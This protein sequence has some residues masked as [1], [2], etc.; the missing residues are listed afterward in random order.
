[1]RMTTRPN[2]PP[3]PCAHQ[4]ASSGRQWRSARI[5]ASSPSACWTHPSRGPS[6]AR[7]NGCCAWP[8]AIRP[9]GWM[10]RVPERLASTWSTCV[11]SSA[12]WCW[13][14]NTKANLRHLPTSAC[15]RCPVPVSPD[16]AVPSII[17][18][19]NRLNVDPDLVRL[20]KRLKLGPLLPTLPERLTL[21]RAQQ[22]DYVA[23]LTLLLADE[24]QRRD[25]QALERHLVQAGFEDRVTLD[26]FDWTSP[27]Q[28][29]RR[30][31]QQVFSLEFLARKE[32]VVFV[33]PV[34]V[35]KTML[36][37]SL[38][39]TS[40]RAGHSVL[41]IRA[42]A[43]LAELGQARADRSYDKVFRRYLAPDLVIL[44]DFG[45][46][47]LTAQQSN[48][49][50]ELIVERHRRASFAIT[51]NRSVDEWLGL[52]DD[53]ILGNSALD[54]L[55]NAAHQIVIEGPSYRAK[56]APKH[57]VVDDQP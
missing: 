5:S 12:S 41:F 33:G 8:N 13:P 46:R 19:R 4:T 22:L 54:R 14:W 17:A 45:L 29:D 35:G 32:H 39:S 16:P 7:V 28:L 49:L 18:S 3:T 20:L 31:L 15:S 56:L 34:G 6:C 1:M 27:V 10:P 44:D 43:L 53:P 55:A 48:D 47:R 37:Q 2:G 42:D 51:S 57:R 50:Y 30:Q 40:V 26:G 24:V 38:G 52:F 21:A 25:Q 9:S 23:F 36:A 11:A